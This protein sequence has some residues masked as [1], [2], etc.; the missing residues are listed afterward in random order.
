LNKLNHNCRKALA[1][2]IACPEHIA[3]RA[4]GSAHQCDRENLMQYLFHDFES[5][6]S[7]LALHGTAGGIASQKWPAFAALIFVSVPSR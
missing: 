4:L 6:A 5:T 2:R 3:T 7:Q 1:Q